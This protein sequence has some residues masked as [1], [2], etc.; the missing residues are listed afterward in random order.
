MSNFEITA[1]HIAELAGD[2]CCCRLLTMRARAA[3]SE[4]EGQ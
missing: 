1:N 2:A 4:R 3:E